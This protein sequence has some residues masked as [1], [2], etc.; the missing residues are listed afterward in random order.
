M[1]RMPSVVSRVRRYGEVKNWRVSS[2]LRRVRSWR[3]ASSA[4]QFKMLAIDTS[5]G[6]H[7]AEV[8]PGSILGL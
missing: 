8:V 2:G 3:P 7:R 6:G 5:S 1:V 4:Y